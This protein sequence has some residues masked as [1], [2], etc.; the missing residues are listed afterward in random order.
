MDA[1]GIRIIRQRGK[2]RT[3]IRTT[4]VGRLPLQVITEQIHMLHG[5][6]IHVTPFSA[7]PQRGVTQG[8]TRY[9][10]RSRISS[11]KFPECQVFTCLPVKLPYR[12]VIHESTICSTYS[13]KL[14][15]S[16]SVP[17]VRTII[18]SLLTKSSMDGFFINIH[19][20]A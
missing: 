19:T 20:M 14:S 2:R 4:I 8:N 1:N 5:G 6:P 9:D 18:G 13:D 7:K 15:A 3:A 17:L 12:P 10:R 16:G 11:F